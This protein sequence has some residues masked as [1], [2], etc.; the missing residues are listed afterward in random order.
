MRAVD[1]TP[2]ELGGI[3]KESALKNS[4]CM[5]STRDGSSYTCQF[6]K[7]GSVVECDP[8]FADTHRFGLGSNTKTMT[9]VMI[10]QAVEEGRLSLSST[11]EE[12]ARQIEKAD[13]KA[14]RP[15]RPIE[16]HAG[17]KD[18]TLMNVLTHHAGFPGVDTTDFISPKK[19]GRDALMRKILKQGPVGYRQDAKD[20]QYMFQ[21]SNEGY[22]F[23]GELLERIS[24]PVESYETLL[25]KKIFEPLGLERA[26]LLSKKVAIQEAQ[27]QGLGKPVAK[28]L[29]PMIAPSAAASCTLREW[30]YFIRHLM[31]GI[32]GN[33]TSDAILRRPESFKILKETQENCFY[34]AGALMLSKKPSAA[35]H[36]GANGIH[37]TL[38]WF[39]V[40]DL[41]KG[42][43]TSVIIVSTDPF[44]DVSKQF[45]YLAQ[46]IHEKTSPSGE[47]LKKP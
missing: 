44:H 25:R 11:I 33:P 3:L 5:Y 15:K 40:G 46:M 35:Y 16:V 2:E 29:D 28:E 9:A 41:E 22:A 8:T 4:W 39:E 43:G 26:R 20:A 23:L 6:L 14:R 24:D 47:D 36:F 17:F 31:S 19:G 27:K 21:Y 32:N 18:I 10:I 12:L 1:L 37:S 42:M 7:D 45:Y 34:G 13:E 38:V 30:M